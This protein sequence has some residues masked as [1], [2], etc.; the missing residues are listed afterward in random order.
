MWSE[1]NSLSLSKKSKFFDQRQQ[2]IPSLMGA[3]AH[4]VVEF[5]VPESII[6]GT[7]QSMLD[8]GDIFRAT[9]ESAAA[10]M[11][12]SADIELD[13]IDYG[14]CS[15]GEDNYFDRGAVV[16]RLFPIT[17]PHSEGTESAEQGQRRATNFRSLC[18]PLWRRVMLFRVGKSRVKV[19]PNKIYSTGL[20]RL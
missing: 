9:R 19:I 4:D 2:N 11:T 13:L 12:A 1:L 8:H 18:A 16:D 14:N 7:I 3:V 15:A 17:A 5:V 10:E 20:T 6:R